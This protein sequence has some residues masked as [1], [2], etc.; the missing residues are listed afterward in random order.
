MQE[1]YTEHTRILIDGVLSSPGE[2]TP[3][4]RQAVET[5]AEH[6]SGCASSQTHPVPH[7]LE[8]YLTKVVLHAYTITDQ[9]SEALREAG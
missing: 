5:Q 4:L 3:R 9:D 7:A 2:T 8:R 6:L 1:R